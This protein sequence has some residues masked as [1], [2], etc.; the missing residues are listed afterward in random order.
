MIETLAIIL[1]VAVL[2]FLRERLR[3]RMG[4]AQRAELD[5]DYIEHGDHPITRLWRLGPETGPVAVCIHGL[6]TPS[7]VW[8]AI[9]QGL[10][11]RGYRVIA[12][13]LWGRGGSDR[14]A[15]AQ[16]EAYFLKQLE[17]VLTHE[18]IDD[19]ITLIG[20]SMG[21]AIATAFAVSAP[22]R[23]AQLILLAPAGLTIRLGS[24]ARF[25]A[26]VPVLGDWVFLT[27]FPLTHRRYLE[28]ERG[29]ETDVPDMVERQVDEL[30]FRGFVPAVLSSMRNMLVVNQHAAHEAIAASGIPVTAIWGGEDTVI[31]LVAMGKLAEANR[32]ARQEVVEDA[33]HGLPYTHAARVLELMEV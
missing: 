11:A 19:Q 28:A 13:D 16:D 3:P 17:E 7:F 29:M 15:G 6:S 14:P 4:V 2:P 24:L 5:G 12:Y 22:E 1:V 10:A 8:E 32:T 9:A 26:K 33:G 27:G 30:R 21:G 18:G 25:C 23:V 20:Y 31:P